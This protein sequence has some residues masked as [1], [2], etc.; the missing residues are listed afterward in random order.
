MASKVT[1][2][3]EECSLAEKPE[4]YSTYFIH[5][6]HFTFMLIYILAAASAHLEGDDWRG[7]KGGRGGA[8]DVSGTITGWAG[9]VGGTDLQYLLWKWS[10]PTEILFQLFFSNH[11]PPVKLILLPGPS[12]A[13]TLCSCN[14]DNFRYLMKRW[15]LL[16]WS[17]QLHKYQYLT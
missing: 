11:P 8:D 12:L 3:S 5:F 1:P 7:R 13:T 15:W 14:L 6:F 16:F 17:R 4:I 9:G 10:S 2:D